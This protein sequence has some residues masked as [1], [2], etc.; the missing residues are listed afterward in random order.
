MK[1]AQ[2]LSL[3]PLCSPVMVESIPALPDSQSQRL[4]WTFLELIQQ[5][6]LYKVCNSSD[7]CQYLN[8]LVNPRRMRGGYGSDRVCLCV[9]LSVCPRAS[10]YMLCLF[11]PVP[12]PVLTIS[13]FPRNTSF[14]QG[15]DLTF[16]CSITLDEAVDTPVT[17]QGSWRRNGTE[18]ADGDDNE[19]IIVSSP[20]MDAPPYQTT[21]RFNLLSVS[22]AGMYECTATV[23]PQNTLF[24]TGT[25][26]SN[27]LSI[28]V[29]GL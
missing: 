4:G 3:S 24:I 23:T 28:T 20:P 14:F 12:P 21:V 18:L 1:L 2:T 9:C 26:S 25:N 7:L 8:L 13:G 22:D 10:C 11:S 6:F 19:R 16:T 17:V 5:V 15:L 27:S 29:A